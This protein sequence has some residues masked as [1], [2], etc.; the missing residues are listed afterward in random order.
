MSEFKC[1]RCHDLDK[2]IKMKQDDWIEACEELDSLSEELSE[3]RAQLLA[4][5]ARE[6][7]LR[8]AADFSLTVINHAL[9][10]DYLGEGSTNGL[11]KD[12]VH[13]LEQALETPAPD[14]KELVGK[15]VDALTSISSV[16]K[17]RHSE[18]GYWESLGAPA[19]CAA[20]L[21]KD[22]EIAREVLAETQAVREKLGMK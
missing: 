20:V 7:V 18:V 12:A 22:T 6:L 10:L 1:G 11:A 16:H 3:L 17:P 9:D 8:K 21:A 5:Q 19:H 2:M 15:L 4:S 14:L 13:K